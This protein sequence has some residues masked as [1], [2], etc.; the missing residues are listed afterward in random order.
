MLVL[1]HSFVKFK[2]CRQIFEKYTSMIFHEHP[3]GESG[4]AQT[5]GRKGKKA[6]RMVSFL[7]FAK[8]PKIENRI[9]KTVFTDQHIR[10]AFLQTYVLVT[11]LSAFL[12]LVVSL[13]VQPSAGYGLLVTRVFLITHDNSPHSSWTS[14]QLVA[15]TST[16]QHTIDKYPC[17]RWDSNPRSQ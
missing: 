8:A 11:K 13:A 14:D 2:F 12:V 16:W 1:C 10:T 5:D 4:N 3:S 17:Y 6:K 7:N 15:E 9:H